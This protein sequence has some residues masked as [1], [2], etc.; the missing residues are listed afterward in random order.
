MTKKFLIDDNEYIRIQNLYESYGINLL[1]EDI[2]QIA[3]DIK[4]AG[5]IKDIE[6]AK[7]VLKT[8]ESFVKYMDE[9]LISAKK[10]KSVSSLDDIVAKLIHI[11]NPSGLAENMGEAKKQVI[12][13]LNAYSQTKRFENFARLK[14]DVVRAESSAKSA[15]GEGQAFNRSS[16]QGSTYATN[17]DN[18]L[19][20][21][22]KSGKNISSEELKNYSQYIDWTKITNA[23]NINDY[24]VLISKAI[25]NPEN[26]KY[27]SSG[28]FE[29]FGIPNFRDFLNKN[30]DFSARIYS[31]TKGFWYFKI[32]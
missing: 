18:I 8:M 3:R 31:D 13:L 15:S 24:N 25:S 19:K 10:I 6:T 30:Q 22:F 21:I 9:I 27:I 11:Y 1:S 4:K 16:N 17:A 23:K 28:G 20:D 26:L 29:K 32:K 5:Y 12:Y 2:G 14:D 7:T